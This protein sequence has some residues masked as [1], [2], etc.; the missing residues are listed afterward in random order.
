[1][2]FSGCAGRALHPSRCRKLLRLAIRAEVRRGEEESR[3][4]EGGSG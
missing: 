2:P 4:G 3:R 1:L